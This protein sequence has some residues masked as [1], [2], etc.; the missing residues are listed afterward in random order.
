MNAPLPPL[1]SRWRDQPILKSMPCA[2][3]NAD[4]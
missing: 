1:E 3:G 2:S 4:E